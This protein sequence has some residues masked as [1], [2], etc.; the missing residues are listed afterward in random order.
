LLEAPTSLALNASRVGASTASLGNLFQ[1]F[2]P[3]QSY[4]QGIKYSKCLL[5]SAS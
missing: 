2:I 4:S 3:K 5:F 1:L